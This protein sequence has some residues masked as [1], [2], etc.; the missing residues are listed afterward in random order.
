MLDGYVSF[1]T[2]VLEHKKERVPLVELAKPARDQIRRVQRRQNFRV[3]V[4][5]RTTVQVGADTFRLNLLDLSAG[6]FLAC[7]S[8]QLLGEGDVIHGSL[9]LDLEKG[10]CP[11]QYS[12][13]V[14]R[15]TYEPTEGDWQFGVEFQEVSPNA[16][17]IVRY[18]MERQ[19]R[20]LRTLRTL[21]QSNQM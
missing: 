5:L 3:P 13:T 4:T 20:F 2:V 17:R 7:A 9:T 6:G 21:E 14:S 12:G 10:E 8:K 11:I 1:D 18:C 16:D 19:R 15:V